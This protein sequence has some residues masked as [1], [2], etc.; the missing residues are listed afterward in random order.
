MDINI[1]DLHWHGDFRGDEVGFDDLDVVG[2]YGSP[3]LNV[4]FYINTENGEVLEVLGEY[5]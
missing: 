5:H 4:N 2:L 1:K 3:S